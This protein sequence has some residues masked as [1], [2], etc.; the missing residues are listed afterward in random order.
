M[1]DRRLEN[2]YIAS[3]IEVTEADLNITFD[4]TWI[5]NLNFNKKIRIRR[6]APKIVQGYQCNVKTQENKKSNIK[7]INRFFNHLRNLICDTNI[8]QCEYVIN[9]ISYLIQNIER[10][11]ETASIIIGEQGSMKNNFTIDVISKLFG[12]YSI[13]N[14]NKIMNIM[15]RFNSSLENKKLIVCNELQSIEN[16]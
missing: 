9:W 2:A 1:I 14:E 4:I 15:R 11:T 10:K 7:L 16:A 12:H 6:I 13:S 3:N 5:S 8:E